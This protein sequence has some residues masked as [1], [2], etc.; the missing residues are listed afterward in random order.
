MTSFGT[1]IIGPMPTNCACLLKVS[2]S[3]CTN[4]YEGLPGPLLMLTAL[5]PL[6]SASSLASEM[7]VKSLLKPPCWAA[8]V[9]T[10]KSQ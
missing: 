1:V 9:A 4:A 6:P 8:M 7:K 3:S 10:S 2:P 5:W